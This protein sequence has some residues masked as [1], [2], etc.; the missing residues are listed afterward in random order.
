M[1]DHHVSLAWYDAVAAELSLRQLTRSL[2]PQ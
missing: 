1:H 2:S